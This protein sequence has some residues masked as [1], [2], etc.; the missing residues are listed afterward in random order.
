[1]SDLKELRYPLVDEL[2]KLKD[3][4]LEVIMASLHLEGYT[5]LDAPQ[6][7]RDLRP[8]PTQ[9]K[10]AIFPE[11][12]DPQDPWPFKEEMPLEEAI[13]ANISRAEKKKKC[14]VVCHTYGVGSAHH[15]MSNGVPVFVPTIV[16]QGLAILIADA[17]T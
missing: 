13:M 7:I 1:L 15:A 4:P 3:A 2:E 17:A 10:I 5:R 6:R 14:W 16:P 9:L 12:R 8:S 11:V